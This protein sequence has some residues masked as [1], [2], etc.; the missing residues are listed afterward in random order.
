MHRDEQI[1]R[2]C[3]LDRWNCTLY[4]RK[5][6]LGWGQV[7]EGYPRVK[8]IILAGTLQN[9]C[10]K[11]GDYWTN[12]TEPEEIFYRW[13]RECSL[14]YKIFISLQVLVLCFTTVMFWLLRPDCILLT[15]L[16]FKSIQRLK[17]FQAIG[18]FPRSRCIHRCM[19]IY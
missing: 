12:I 7:S 8:S 16:E 15:P 17:C 1:Y 10:T 14:P 6:M 18:N 4:L 3:K 5:I 11:P 19:C 2:I 13:K 9:P